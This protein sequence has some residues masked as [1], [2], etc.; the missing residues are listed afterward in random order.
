MEAAFVPS[1]VSGSVSRTTDLEAAVRGWTAA[2]PD[3]A[4]R[5]E[6]DGL[7]EAG[8]FDELAD[9]MAG[10]LEFGTAGLRGRVEAG[11]NRMNRAVVITATRGLAG[12]LLDRR[13]EPLVVVGRDARLSSERFMTDTVGVL[14]AAG[15]R[16][17]YFPEPVPTPIVAF[18]A[19]LLGAE[20]AVVITASHNPPQDNGYKV[21]DANFAQIVPPVDSDIAA[22]IASVGAAS[23]V[24]SIR[25]P[26]GSETDLATAVPDDVF[27]RY[28][29]ALAEFRGDVAGAPERRIVYTPLHGVGGKYVVAALARFGHRNV[30]PV[31]EQFEPDGRFPTVAFPNPEEP[32][33][34]DLALELAAER[35][36]DL[37]LANDPDTDR[38]AVAVPDGDGGFRPLTG[39]QVG[40]LLADHIL[41]RTREPHPLVINSIVSTPLLE[42][43]ARHHDAAYT[44]TLTGFKWIWNAALEMEAEGAGRFVFGFEEA[45]GYS[46]GRIVRDKDGISAA[47]VFADM[48]AAAA[49]EGRSVLDELA[50]IYGE[51]G[52]WVSTQLSILRQGPRGAAEI[53]AALDRLRATPPERLGGHRVTGIADYSVGAEER[54]RWLAATD[55]LVMTLGGGGRALV[56]PSGTE[57]KLKI[58]VDLN[59]TVGPAEAMAAEP[60]LRRRADDL[61]RAVAEAL[62]FA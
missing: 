13:D 2:D 4:T 49:A 19:K 62:Q 45:L 60:A 35:R 58:Y 44:T 42:L 21:Y 24:P 55:L 28:L 47:V 51:H 53:G 50:R 59:E 48:A 20:A 23:D 37:V 38:L 33:A 12:Y 29:D 6:L 15:V 43:I 32:G 16:V 18:A 9:R 22:A 27:E 14:A 8:H 54:P 52:L 11:S 25:D 61:A 26:F 17:R 39:N 41:H 31:A 46:V 3:P 57:P 7:L 10:T 34:L 40:A 5:A 56:R 1:V 30:L 36:A